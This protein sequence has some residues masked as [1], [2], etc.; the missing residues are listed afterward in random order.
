MIAGGSGPFRTWKVVGV[1]AYALFMD[2]FVYGL[3]V[4]L[5]PFTPVGTMSEDRL[6]LLYGS[7]AIGVLG[8]TPLFGYLGDR[9]GCRRPMIIG[10]CLSAI[11]AL[12]FWLAPSY[13]LLVLARVFQGAASAGTWTAGLALVAEN[14]PTR[15][16][17]MMGYALIGSTAGSILGPSL[18]GGLFELGGF[19]LPF[20]VTGV[21]V[22]LDAAMRIFLLPK[23]HASS[24]ASAPLLGLLSNRA[25]LIPAIAV[26]LAAFGWGIVEPL[27]PD[28]LS[29]FG[30]SPTVV[31]LFFTISTIAYGLCAPVVSWVSG[32][33][34]IKRVIA[35]GVVAMAASLVLL[36]LA[37]GPVLA[38]VALC[39]LSISFAFALNPTSAELGNAVDRLGLA[40]YAAVYAVYNISYSVGM[41]ATNSLAS[42]ATEHIGFSGT[43]ACAA[44]ALLICAPLLLLKDRQ[45]ATASNGDQPGRV[46][47]TIT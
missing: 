46:E 1:V 4:P 16:V 35:G 39:L 20:V 37:P 10:V 14:Y 7:Y 22:A 28:R 6:A 24:A 25:I 8:A 11:A 40:C 43:L 18:G 34:A 23:D 38:G 17:E 9:L 5:T 12:L 33:F 41:M 3:V 31:G 32:H 45:A 19:S 27:L 26:M 30:A 2:Y 36:G 42:A 15:R 13:S 29:R 21:L 47:E 44:A